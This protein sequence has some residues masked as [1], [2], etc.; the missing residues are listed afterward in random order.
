MS[1]TLSPGPTW[2][3][4]PKP[5]EEI[6]CTQVELEHKIS[7]LLLSRYQWYGVKIDV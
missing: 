7:A 5:E 3:Q 2:G 1:S 4:T 6:Q